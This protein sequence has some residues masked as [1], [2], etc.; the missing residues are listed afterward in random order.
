MAPEPQNRVTVL[1][2]CQVSPRPPPSAGKPRSLPLTFYDLA[3]W[4]VPHVQR[5]FFYD[6]ADLLGGSEFLLRELPLFE[7]SMAVALHHF[8]PLAGKLPC[9]MPTDAAPEIVFSDGDSVR[10][11][12]AVGNDDFDYLASDHARDTARLRPLLPPLLRNGG[13][14]DVFAIQLTVFPLAGICIGTTLHHAVC[15]G[16]SYVH[17]MK[18]W[19][20]IHRCGY[21]GGESMV[22]EALPLFDRSFVRDNDGLREV[23]LSD[24][25][26]YAAAEGEKGI[27][28]CHCHLAGG[29]TELATFR[30]TDRLLRWLGRQV[31]SETSARRCSPYAL[32]CGAMWAGI[33]RARGRSAS[34]GFVTGC[35]PRASPPVPANYFGNCLGLCRVEEETEAKQGWLDAVTASA[36]AIW[37][38]I[39]GLAEEGR[40]FRDARGWVRLVREYASAR[41]VTV[42]GSPKLGVYA[43]TDL[44]APWGRPRKVEIVSVERTGAL[45]LSESGRDGDGG[46]EV[47]LALPRVEM[48]AFRA[49]YG[50]LLVAAE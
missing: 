34:F 19:A 49:F 4:E 18:T 30:F 7:K 13:S 47:G 45:A 14:Q 11:T 42:A 39:E 43:A 31:E 41:A 22:V 8:Y 38:A 26:A 24:H 21:S 6:N 25:R 2:Q 20:A 12:V 37:R 27:H 32:A 5:L 44:G 35:K 33:V 9:R 50:D 23:F 3:F 36:A 15:D 28:E 29:T 16:S 40:V 1:E 17:F 10:L 48:E 46:I